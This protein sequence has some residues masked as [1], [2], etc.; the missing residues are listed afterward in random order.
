VSTALNLYQ[1]TAG[2]RDVVVDEPSEDVLRSYVAR[3][4]SILEER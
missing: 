4:S 1:S 2:K 3:I